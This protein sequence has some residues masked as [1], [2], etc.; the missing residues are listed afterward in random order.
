MHPSRSMRCRVLELEALTHDIRGVTW[1]SRQAT[2]DFL[3][4][5]VAQL[6]FATACHAIIRWPTRR[7][8]RSSC[9]TSA[10]MPGGAPAL[11]AEQL[12]IGDPVKCPRR[13]GCVPA[14]AARGPVLLIAGGSGLAPIQSI[15]STLVGRGISS[16]SSLLRRARRTRPLPRSN[17]EG[18]GARHPAQDHVGLSEQKGDSGRAMAWCMRQLTET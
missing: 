13:S 11:V 17:A 6:E 15:A 12:K 14:R 2:T 10:T 1:R 5:T 18:S 16:R 8:S 9:S 3:R 4:R 7:T